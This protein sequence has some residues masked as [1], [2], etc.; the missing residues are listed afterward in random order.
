MK[1]LYNDN[2]SK[3]VRDLKMSKIIDPECLDYERQSSAIGTIDRILGQMPAPKSKKKKK[4]KKAAE[5]DDK[6]ADGGEG[7][8][9]PGAP[10]KKK[11]KKKKAKKSTLPEVPVMRYGA[12]QTC[13]QAMQNTISWH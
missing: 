11:K 2:Q 5:D 12:P 4:K 8:P 10:A 13:E 1:T 6:P 3:S 7:S 9:E